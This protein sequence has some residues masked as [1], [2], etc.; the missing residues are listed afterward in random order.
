MSGW[1]KIKDSAEYAGVSSRTIRRWLKMGL[2]HARMP[3]GMIL[4]SRAALDKF[5]GQFA[6]TKN[7]AD[8]I[9]EEMLQ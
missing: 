2:V 4:I 3:G 1:G 8:K 6:V 9:V 7:E 5:I